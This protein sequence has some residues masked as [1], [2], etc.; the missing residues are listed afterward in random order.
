MSFYLI[1]AWMVRVYFRYTSYKMNISLF[2]IQFIILFFMQEIF[3]DE[4]MQNFPFPVEFYK[5]RRILNSF[6]IFLSKLATK[7]SVIII[8][9]R[10]I[11]ALLKRRLRIFFSIACFTLSFHHYSWKKDYS[12]CFFKSLKQD[13]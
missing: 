1:C 11:Y 3:F 6:D 2:I 12:R 9:S 13:C 7:P 4:N 8:I 5:N 10:S